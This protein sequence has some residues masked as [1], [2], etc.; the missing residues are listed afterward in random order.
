MDCNW[1]KNGENEPEL[2]D[3][4]MVG[5]SQEVPVEFFDNWDPENNKKAGGNENDS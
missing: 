1:G 5:G 3:D 4:W 2:W